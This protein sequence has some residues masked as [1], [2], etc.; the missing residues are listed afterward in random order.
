MSGKEKTPHLIITD[1]RKFQF[2]ELDELISRAEDLSLSE[3]E[4]NNLAISI[5]RLKFVISVQGSDGCE[6]EY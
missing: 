6:F 2:D 5:H 1:R 4:L 3:E